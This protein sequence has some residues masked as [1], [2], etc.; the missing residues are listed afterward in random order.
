MSYPQPR[1]AFPDAAF[2]QPNA[3]QPQPQSWQQAAPAVNVDFWTPPS[4]ATQPQMPTYASAAA[5][6]QGAPQNNSPP[7][8]IYAEPWQQEGARQRP[9]VPSHY[10]GGAPPQSDGLMNG[11]PAFMPAQLNQVMANPMTGMALDFGKQALGKNVSDYAFLD[12]RCLRDA[13]LVSRVNDA[14]RFLGSSALDRSACLC[15]ICLFCSCHGSC[16]SCQRCDIISTF[17]RQAQH[18]RVFMFWTHRGAEFAP[19][20]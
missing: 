10:P 17:V 18:S 20:C 3:G 4:A 6:Q 13:P 1:P 7:Q 8:P 5:S 19:L 15:V 12:N 9:V 11:Q 14:M 16:P 2:P